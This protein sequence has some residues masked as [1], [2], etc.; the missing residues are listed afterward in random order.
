MR[1]CFKLG[2]NCGSYC[3][4]KGSISLR[5]FV[6]SLRADFLSDNLTSERTSS[7]KLFG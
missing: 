2:I 3:V 1:I 7:I 6:F 4:A 5:A